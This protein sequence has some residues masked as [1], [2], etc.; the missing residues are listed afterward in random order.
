MA[1]MRTRK[2]RKFY[3]CFSGDKTSIPQIAI[4]M[5]HS[6]VP[7]EQTGTAV[8]PNFVFVQNLLSS[9]RLTAF[10][11]FFLFPPQ[12]RAGPSCPGHSCRAGH[13]NYQVTTRLQDY[14]VHGSLFLDGGKT[15]VCVAP[16]N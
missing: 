15:A 3:R 12:R 13:S 8:V 1:G 7:R 2:T 10:V 16:P 11:C 5:K 6:D 4:L 14:T 9:A